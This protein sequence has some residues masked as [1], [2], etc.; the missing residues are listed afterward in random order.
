M[1]SLSCGAN[2]KD[3]SRYFEVIAIWAQ[4][5]W[6]MP[7]GWAMEQSAR[8]AVTKPDSVPVT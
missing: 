6:K 8:W 1:M 3:A 2:R 4:V 7:D 5:L